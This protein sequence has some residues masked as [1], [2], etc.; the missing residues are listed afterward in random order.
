MYKGID[1]IIEDIDELDKLVSF[2]TPIMQLGDWEISVKFAPLGDMIEGGELSLGDNTYLHI[3]KQSCIRLLSWDGWIEY[4]DK[5]NI[6]FSYDMEKVLVHELLHCNYSN[7][8]DGIMNDTLHRCLEE[9]SRALVL[10]KRAGE[11]VSN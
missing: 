10:V 3:Q 6:P 1:F 9:T 7:T 8:Y 4:K 2:W 11:N 5:F